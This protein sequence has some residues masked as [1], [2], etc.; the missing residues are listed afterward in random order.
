MEGN[1]AKFTY[2]GK[3]YRISDNYTA[4]HRNYYTHV[5]LGFDFIRKYFNKLKNELS[6]DFQANLVWSIPDLSV[7]FDHDLRISANA[8]KES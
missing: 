6:L 2:S 4:R 7:H 3:C 8:T 1:A 5:L